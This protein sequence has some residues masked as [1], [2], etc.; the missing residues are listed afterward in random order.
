[1]PSNNQGIG[2][3]DWR[4]KTSRNGRSDQKK[5]KAWLGEKKAE[6][7]GKPTKGFP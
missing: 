3:P 4:V 7:E 6:A 1:V 5:K 2:L